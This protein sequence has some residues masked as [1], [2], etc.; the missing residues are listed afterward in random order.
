MANAELN[1]EQR[2]LAE[3]GTGTSW[4]K[5]GPYL[6]E[7]QWGTVREDYS[8]NGDAWNYF[9]HD[10]A[11]SRAYRSG[12]DGLAGFSDDKQRLCFALA[13]WN[14]QDPIL[15]ERLF[16][17][18]G[19]EGNHGEDVKEYYFY[20][21]STPTHSYM[22]WLYKYPQ[23]AYPYEDLVQTNRRRSQ[24]GAG[25]RAPRHR[26]L[27]RRPLLRRLR[28]VRQGLPRG[29]TH[30]HHR[31]EP[32]TGGGDAARPA[33]AL[34]P[35]CMDAG[36]LGRRSPS[37]ARSRDERARE[38]SSVSRPELGERWLCVEGDVPLLFTENETNNQRLFGTPNAGPYVKDGI[39]DYV[40]HRAAGGGEPG[41]APAPRSAAHHTLEV[42]AGGTAVLRLR[43]TDVA[44][45]ASK[46]PF[47][48]FDETLRRAPPRSGRVLSR[49]HPVLSDRR[50]SPGHAPGARPACCGRNSTSCSMPTRGS[51]STAAIPSPPWRGPTRNREWGH[52]V[53]DDIISMP[54]KWE[55][56]WY[57][58]W[59]LAFHAVA[60]A[61]GRHRLRQAAARPDAQRRCTCIRTGRSPPTNGTSAT[62]TRRCTPGPRSAVYRTEQ[63]VRG[64]GDLEF[65]KRSFGK[66]LANFTWWVNRKDRFGKNVFEGGFLGLDNIGVFDRSAPLPTGGYLEQAD[67]TA[68]MAL[69]QPEHAGVGY[70]NRRV[71]PELRGSRRRSSSTTVL[72]IGHAISRVGPDGCGTRRTA[73]S[74]TCCGS[75]TGARRVSRCAPWSAS[76]R[77]APRA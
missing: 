49:A 62:S 18:T 47:A 67:G 55:Y 32:G 68:W 4:K 43:L 16:G 3:A 33:H 36:R 29:H 22:K 1:A 69:L 50:R 21:D 20:L 27:R 45:E 15:K 63:A 38:P 66:L 37:C 54:D 26:Y 5:W 60:L 17:L 70:R 12:E 23:R 59:D 58:A 35:Q 13:L 75:R 25:V 9:T 28:R 34:V 44:P 76:C 53:N 40:V 19:G 30:P 72:W 39:N 73:S 48:G 31:G 64:E 57:A 14:G 10:Q 6:S 77:C 2:R 71:R 65:L 46:D 11:R 7:R 56:P 51:R 8:D 42:E 61:V 52:M 74:T 24:A 41:T